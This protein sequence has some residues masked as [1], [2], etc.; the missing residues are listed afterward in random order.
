M[1]NETMIVRLMLACFIAIVAFGCGQKSE[2]TG[3]PDP[4]GATGENHAATLQDQ[5]ALSAGSLVNRESDVQSDQA[6]TLDTLTRAVRK[7]SAE[8]QRVPGNLNELVGAGYLKTIPPAPPGKKF[9]ISPKR[10]E[11]IVVNQ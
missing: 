5:P 1:Y 11:V 4:G 8:Q 9:V 2:S 10:V 3:R 6:T 7:Y